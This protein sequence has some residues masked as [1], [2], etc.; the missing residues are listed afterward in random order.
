MCQGAVGVRFEVVRLQ[1]K[2]LGIVGDGGVEV[3]VARVRQS[4]PPVVGRVARLERDDGAEVGDGLA[5]VTLARVGACPVEQRLHVGRVGLQGGCVLRDGDVVQLALD[6][7][8]AV[9]AAGHLRQPLQH[10]AEVR[11]PAGDGPCG[12]VVDQLAPGVVED[13]AVGAVGVGPAHQ[14]EGA[15]P[16]EVVDV[17]VRA[18]PHLALGPAHDLRRGVGDGARHAAAQRRLHAGRGVAG[19]GVDDGA[20]ERQAGVQ[21][22][23]APT[24]QPLGVLL[25]PQ[26]HAA[27]TQA[28]V[29]HAAVVGRLQRPRQA[30]GDLEPVLGRQRALLGDQLGQRLALEVFHHDVGPRLLLRVRTGIGEDPDQRRIIEVLQRAEIAEQRL[31]I[32]VEA[33]RPQRLD[34]DLLGQRAVLAQ[35]G[36]AEA[37][38]AEDALR[39]VAGKWE[40]LEGVAV[41]LD[42]AAQ[43]G[44]GF[45]PVAPLQGGAEDVVM[46]LGL[47]DRVR[48]QAGDLLEVVLAGLQ[49][50]DD[51]F[52]LRQA[53][54]QRGQAAPLLGGQVAEA[55]HQVE[56]QFAFAVAAQRQAVARPDGAGVQV[57]AALEVRDGLVQV[58]AHLAEFVLLRLNIEHGNL[59]GALAF[60]S[61]LN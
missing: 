48:D 21:Q 25:A 19:A 18:D 35:K 29:Q 10:R 56:D 39:L 24:I 28:A 32:A 57:V 53:V 54:E 17:G 22:L 60:L 34:D 46:R 38:G 40:R 52:E 50:A 44:Q 41:Q 13:H 49:V 42:R 2:R 6:A 59:P 8:D 45:R 4:P 51:D 5:V 43:R 47:G 27:R 20:L 55:L 30:P 3:P 26:Q 15:H 23:D 33:V 12:A 36:R 37:A 7:A 11:R 14:G 58:L 31:E 61:R 1:F 9:V 16:A